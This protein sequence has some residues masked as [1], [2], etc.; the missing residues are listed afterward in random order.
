MSILQKEHGAT[1]QLSPRPA[2]GDVTSL[3]CSLLRSQAGSGSFLRS[4][5]RPVSCVCSLSPEPGH[6]WSDS[7]L[8]SPGP[9]T[10]EA[11]INVC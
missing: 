10:E 9:G 3:L 8:V 7:D 4:A 1:G 11:W 5:P 6:G 2:S